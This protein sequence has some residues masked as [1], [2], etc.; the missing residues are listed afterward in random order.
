MRSKDEIMEI[1]EEEDVEFIRLQFTDILGNLKNIAITPGQLERVMNNMYAIESRVLFDGLYELE[2]ELYLYPDLDTFVI[3]PWRPQQGKVGKLTC[4]LCYED[5]TLCDFSPRTVLQRA[6][7]NAKK[8]GYTFMINPECEIF[9]FHTDENRNPTIVT[10]EKASY[11]DVG[12]TDF[13]ENARR[14]MVLTLEEMGMEVESSH[15]EKAPAQHGIYFGEMEAF[16]T[17]DQLANFKL[18]ARSIATR[19]G[20]YATFMP[21]PINGVEG[22]GMHLNF[23]LCKDGVNLFEDYEKRGITEEAAYFIGGIMAH[24]QALC[25]VANPLVNSYKRLSNGNAPKQIDWGKRG[26]NNLIKLHGRY[27]ETKV[28][29]RFP[30]GAANPYLTIAACIAAGLDGIRNKILPLAEGEVDSRKLPANLY[31]SI[32][33]LEQDTVVKEALGEELAVIY[34]QL[35]KEEWNDYMK[36]VSDWE[37]NRYLSKM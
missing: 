10:H 28:E 36:T 8:E 35:K 1:I 11:M 32:L 5:G 18:A 3:L 15:H 12:P 24:V 21:K 4:D 14:D 2:E 17:A 19:F 7:D 6:V 37:I 13:G 27:G 22:S 31:E 25:A 33:Y 9:L 26:K 23:S 34:G 30:D 20:L 29:L 16:D